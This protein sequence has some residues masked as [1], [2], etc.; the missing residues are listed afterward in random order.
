M[1]NANKPDPEELPSSAQ[2]LRSTILAFIAAVV[3]LV[4]IVLPAEYNI[5]PT[6]IGKAIGLA[7]MGE[8]KQELAREAEED[9][10]KHGDQSSFLDGILGLFVST[11]NAQETWRD[12]VTF[13]LAPGEYTEVKLVMGEGDNAEYEWS[14]DG[15]RINYDLHAHGGG[16]S[17]DYVKGRGE[18]SGEGSFEAPFAGDHGWFWRNRDKVD[19]TVT[20]KTRGDYSELKQGK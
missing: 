1:Y 16:K 10:N 15:G 8:I 17:V 5:D 2:L 13:T 9:R 20:L 12:E 6:G 11:A 4:T 19:V 3:I 18:T 14:T 7:E